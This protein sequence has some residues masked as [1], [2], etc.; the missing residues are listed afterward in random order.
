MSLG[1]N[2][3]EEMRGSNNLENHWKDIKREISLPHTECWNGSKWEGVK[4]N[5]AEWEQEEQRSEFNKQT[6]PSLLGK[7]GVKYKEQT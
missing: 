7:V 5:W 6:E 2:R 4:W 1:K 3:A